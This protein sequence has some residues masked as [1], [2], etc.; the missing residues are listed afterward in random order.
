VQD[1][2]PPRSLEHIEQSENVQSCG[3]AVLL[4]FDGVLKSVQLESQLMNR[5]LCHSRYRIFRFTVI[6]NTALARGVRSAD[7]LRVDVLRVFSA[8][9]SEVLGPERRVA[10]GQVG[11]GEGPLGAT[12]VSTPLSS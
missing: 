8:V 3:T 7:V 9:I 11:S 10:V 12:P 5:R 4:V 1:V 2:T 6:A